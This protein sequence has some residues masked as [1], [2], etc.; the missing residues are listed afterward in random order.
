MY[1]NNQITKKI[2]K[3]NN[4]NINNIEPIKIHFLLNDFKRNKKNNLNN[5]FS[6]TLFKSKSITSSKVPREKKI[7]NLK[8]IF[9]NIL[10]KKNNKKKIKNISSLTITKSNSNKK[11]KYLPNNLKNKIK[12]S[13]KNQIKSNIKYSEFNNDTFRK[14]IKNRNFINKNSKTH[15]Y[16]INYNFNKP[17]TSLSSIRC[18]LTSIN[19][20]S[21]IPKQINNKPKFKHHKSM[22]I[23]TNNNT[24]TIYKLNNKNDK[25]N[26]VLLKLEYLKLKTNNLLDKYYS[27]NKELKNELKNI[28]LEY[29]YIDN[30]NY[31]YNYYKTENIIYDNNT[32]EEKDKD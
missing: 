5:C 9:E 14:K 23:T 25:W 6:Y 27:L 20:F 1:V 18:S 7:N 16:N 24:N 29:N 17:K 2:E 26:K 22:N 3:H 30:N 32:N 4:N 11:N 15:T 10:N 12:E 21:Y 31:N 13:F 28:N 19:R 8:K